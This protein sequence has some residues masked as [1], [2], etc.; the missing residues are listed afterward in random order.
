LTLKNTIVASSKSGANCAG[1][2]ISKGHNLSDDGSCGLAGTGD[3]NNTAAGLDPAGLTSNGGATQ[4]VDLLPGSPAID[5]VPL[6]DCTDTSG[7]S[8]ATDQRGIGRPQG[9]ACDIGSV[10]LV[11]DSTP[12]VISANVTGASGSNGWYTSNVSVTWNVTDPESTIVSTSG[13][14][15]VTLTAD[16]AGTTLTCSATNAVALSSAA[17]VTLKI[18]KTPPVVSGSRTP[19]PNAAGWNNSDVTV[20][21]AC[22]DGTSG[23]GYVSPVSAV[24]LAEGA[25]QSVAGSCTDK[26]GNQAT[27]VVGGISIDKTKPT[28][29]NLAANPNPVAINNGVTLSAS[30]NDAGGSNLAAADYSVNGST[31]S[32]L[33]AASGSSAA[34]SGALPAF[35]STGVY[36]VCVHARDV[37]GNVG[38]DECL[39][40]PVYDPNGGF[41]TGG[42]WINSS[43]GAYSADPLLA[44]KA[45]F[46]FESRYQRGATVPSG[47]TQ[48]QFRVAN[49]N[50][51]STSYA[52]LVIAGARAQYRGTGTIN[53]AGNYDFL[54]TAVDGEM[55]G[56]GGADRSRIKIWGAGG[57]VYDNQ[58]GADDNADPTTALG[59]GSVVIHVE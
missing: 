17:S 51:R 54:L 8:V 19:A 43:P 12:P 40:L 39:F 28:T 16:T 5:A 44:G 3:L 21:F 25:N 13:C 6:A 49:L 46:G 48:F 22:T 11:P 53:G 29:A 24:L 37:A 9:A 36:S 55:P 42:G 20:N 45:T 4:T 35:P 23:V 57:V 26:A 41:V 1:T 52:W 18:D 47:D 27:A 33:G 58:M 31:A 59:G 30:L 38:A 14:D 10:E 56:G 15:P 2:I 32:M 34:V 7:A 50:F